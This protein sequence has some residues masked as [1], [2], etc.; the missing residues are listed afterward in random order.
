M[1][2][3]KYEGEKKEATKQ[4]FEMA[5]PVEVPPKTGSGK[6]KIGEREKGALKVKDYFSATTPRVQQWNPRRK[7]EEEKCP[8]LAGG[9]GGRRGEK[10]KREEKKEREERERERG[11]GREGSVERGPKRN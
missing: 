8:R 11:R 1:R 7:R 5:L 10:Q 2:R 3:K 4:A 9:G 6:E